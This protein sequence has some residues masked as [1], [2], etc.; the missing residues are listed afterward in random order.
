MIILDDLGV[1]LTGTEVLSGITGT[2]RPGDYVWLSGPNGAGKSTLLRCLAGLVGPSHGTV[3]V[4]G[5]ESGSPQA[6]SHVGYLPDTPLL[7]DVMTPREHLDFLAELWG[8]DA[9][10]TSALERF[11][12]DGIAD[13]YARELSL[14]QRQRLALAVATF[15]QPRVLLLD[16]PFNGLDA[17]TTA[18]VTQTLRRHQ[19]SGGVAIVAT[20][21]TGHTEHN[22]HLRL[23]GGR[24]IEEIAVP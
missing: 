24:L 18:L 22:R 7:Y 19:L 15:H 11:R 2:I 13:R 20:H 6:R 4:W 21:L 14:G 1:T 10:L 17:D 16:E 23:D 9:D 12:L 3:S 5:A 8:T